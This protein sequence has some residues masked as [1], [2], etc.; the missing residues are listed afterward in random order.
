MP[1]I[2]NN[3]LKG[4]VNK[5]LSERLTPNGQLVDAFNFVVSS[6]D[7]SKAGVGK[8][9]LGTT[10]MTDFELLQNDNPHCIGAFADEGRFLL[11]LFIT[12]DTFDYVIKYNTE[13]DTYLNLITT[14]VGGVLNFSRNYR[15]THCDIFT[16]VEGDD[17][18]SW[19]DGY[20]P[21]RI[22][23]ANKVYAVDVTQEEISVIKPAPVFPPTVAQPTVINLPSGVN[24]ET[25]ELEDRFISFSYRWKYND[26][27]Y[28]SFAP[29]SNYFF[30]P[31]RFSVDYDS[32]ENNGMVNAVNYCDVNFNTGSRDVIGVDVL[33]KY[34]GLPNVYVLDK[35]DKADESWANNT[36]RTV[37]FFNNKRY[38]T[39]PESQWF[40]SFDNVPLTAL[41]QRRIGNRLVYGN[42]VEGRDMN[43]ATDFNVGLKT[44]PIIS[45]TIETDLLTPS[46]L[47]VSFPDDVALNSGLSFVVELNLNIDVSPS[48]NIP[49]YPVNFTYILEDDY[50]DIQNFLVDSGFIDFLTGEVTDNFN[51]WVVLNL[52]FDNI[53][54]VQG[55]TVSQTPEQF[56]ALVFQINLPILTY[57][58]NN[59]IDFVLPITFSAI[60]FMPTGSILNDVNNSINYKG[61]SD[62]D[63]AFTSLSFLVIRVESFLE[64]DFGGAGFNFTLEVF[65]NGVS[66]YEQAHTSSTAPFVYT[67]FDDTND[68]ESKR[69]EYTFSVTTTNNF[70]S[71]LSYRV[72]RPTAFYQKNISSTT[73]T[74]LITTTTNIPVVYERNE[75][76]FG[77]N[78][79]TSMKS[80]RSYEVG[81]IYKDKEGRKTTVFPSNNNTIF[82]PHENNSTKNIITVEFDQDYVHPEWAYS[83]QFVIKQNRLD[84]QT[85]YSLIFYEDG[86]YR[87]VKLNGDNKNK[88]KE[89]DTLIVKAD[90]SGATQQLV[91]LSVLEV[92]GKEK[93]FLEDNEDPDENPILEESGLYMKL[94]KEGNISFDYNENTFITYAGGQHLR[95]PQ[96][97]FTSPKFLDTQAVPEPLTVKAGSVINIKISFS[98]K[99]SIAYNANYEKRFIVGS[100]YDT[101]KLWFETEVENLG[102]FGKN[103]TW[104]GYDN[105]S[106]GG[107]I[108]PGY[109]DGDEFNAISGWGFENDSFYVIA[110]RKGT[111]KRNITTNVSFEIRQGSNALIFETEPKIDSQDI[112][113]ETP[114][115]Y[116]TSAT[117]PIPYVRELTNTYN[118]FSFGNGVESNRFKDKFNSTPF[119][120]DFFPTSVSEDEYRQVNRFADLTYSEVFQESTNVNRLNEFNLSLANYKDDIEKSYGSIIRMDSDETDLLII[121][122]GKTSKVLFQKDLLFNT[123]ATTNLSRISQVFGQQVMYAG[124]Y[125][126]S[127]YGESYSEYGSNS[128][129]TDVNRGVVVR[130]NNSNGLR[131]ISEQGMTDYF[132]RLFRDN[133]ITNII[134]AYDSF[135]DI[136]IVNVKYTDGYVTW[137]YS[138]R[139]EGFLT[140]VPLNPDAFVRMNN[141]LYSVN[142]GILHEHNVGFPNTFYGV[143]YP[144]EF[145]FNFSQEPSTRKIFKAI[146]IEGNNAL[147]M[148][149]TTDIQQGVIGN[150][151]FINKEGVF[152]SHIRGAGAIDLKATSVFGLGRLVALSGNIIVLANP[153]QQLSIGDSIYNFS[154]QLVGVVTDI[155]GD[156]IT[157]STVNNLSPTIFL[158]AVK[159]QGVNTSGV[160]GYYMR[161]DCSVT[162]LDRLE[163]F[164]INA[165]IS[166]SFE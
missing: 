137:Y 41:T 141:R 13:L 82:I 131:E 51:D 126:I 116:L 99:G 119:Y 147:S 25:N 102:S 65:K 109:G 149:L 93:D 108:P 164:A 44:L 24:A 107:S 71:T 66:V 42:F 162:T 163:V 77:Q 135:Y 127:T 2:Q 45:Q 52:P 79:D 19:T 17:L 144:T 29:F 91:K 101:V 48:L 113:F 68:S 36:L 32:M 37:T 106:D 96:R 150:T 27:F 46:N 21:P 125:G 28:S 12:S 22:I 124:E 129:W 134:S 165:D 10:L 31:K 156:N 115:V 157:L 130:L 50:T 155:N 34:E 145:S 15:V 154:N 159:N 136:Y 75:L 18:V 111:F 4:T 84:Y 78:F 57:T 114:Q 97:C 69:G 60:S 118:C 38:A 1:K 161:A 59:V 33:F 40:R 152:Y 64:L 23:N 110:H 105:I 67:V 43:R 73:P 83:Y 100:D 5:D 86:I 49:N 76:F 89:G 26:G 7:N 139:D 122:E 148:N 128:F 151:D 47:L 121:Q 140:R 166:K 133:T 117:R 58:T 14:P 8:N 88:V 56:D 90:L 112:Y 85:I 16:S 30:V 63:I 160:L 6:E 120:I 35:Y 54:Y 92:V 53:N 62:P 153:T 103:F 158:Y 142:D 55:F 123:D 81:I 20:N 80:N 74:T 138:P 104:N 95:Y 146:S 61:F 87:W 70:N 94:K 39:L 3:F 132:K 143:Q 72:Y 9:I 98:A 11:Y